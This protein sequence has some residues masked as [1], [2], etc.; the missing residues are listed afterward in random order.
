[1]GFSM[2]GMS[3]STSQVQAKPMRAVNAATDALNGKTVTLL[4]V[5]DANADG[6]SNSGIKNLMSILPPLPKNLQRDSDQ[7]L[8]PEILHYH[9]G[10]GLYK[11]AT[12]SV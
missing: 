6:S 9:E 2:A 4:Q 5:N 12:I 3:T 7:G 8:D 10:S 1:M 11:I